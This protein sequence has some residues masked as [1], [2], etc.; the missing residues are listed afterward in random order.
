M[1]KNSVVYY[2]HARRQCFDKTGNQSIPMPVE[3]V[4]QVWYAGTLS[5]FN[6]ALRTL[7]INDWDMDAVERYYQECD[8]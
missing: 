2:D 3:D 1:E 4:K 6:L 8:K 7:A 5:D